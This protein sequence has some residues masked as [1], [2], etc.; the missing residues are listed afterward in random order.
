MLPLWAVATLL[1]VVIWPQA[2]QASVIKDWA[3][4]TDVNWATGSNWV[5]GSKPGSSDAA[6]FA[7]HTTQY[8]PNVGNSGTTQ[9]GELM[10][11]GGDWNLTGSGSATLQINGSYSGSS[12]VGISATG[13]NNT[14][15]VPTVMFNADQSWDIETGASLT[16]SGYV[17]FNKMGFT[18]TGDGTLTLSHDNSADKFSTGTLSAGT[19]VV[20]NANALGDLT[21]PLN[22]NGGTL[23]LATDTS[24]SAYDMVVGGNATI[25]S[26]RATAGAGI[27]HTLGTL[28]IG[29]N[30]LTVQKGTDVTSGTAG[31]T[32]GA[33]TLTG[34]ATIN[35]NTGAL[36]TLGAVSG[37]GKNFAIG[38]AG[39]TT[40]SGV[41][42]TTTG[43]LTKNGAGT[44][45]LSGANTYTGATTI[46]AGTIL[47]QNASAFSAGTAV[48]V[49]NGAALAVDSG[50]TLTKT[51]TWQSGSILGGN[52]KYDIGSVFGSSGVHIAPGTSIGTL[53]IDDGVN[54]SSGGILDVQVSGA[55]ADLLNITNTSGTGDLTL[56]GTSVLNVTE[57]NPGTFTSIAIVTYAGTRSGQFTTVNLPSA[58][59]SISYDDLGKR[60][61]LMPEPQTMTLMGVGSLFIGVPWIR[62]RKRRTD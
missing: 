49:Q 45:T 3:G 19:L 30:T 11:T 24:V 29:A 7:T 59:Y 31:L 60:I 13:G 58:A 53:T 6:R 55:T 18:K 56:G 57:L 61:L 20:A 17:N 16:V 36:T 39:N 15:S 23:D 52:G 22:L 50:V 27:T 47:V 32:F 8:Q 62:K 48:T 1:V 9:V 33:V 43:T 54:L 25:Q 10:F 38:G 41:I 46:S 2:A 14:I 37:S 5:G 34:N 12:G 35:T 40:I 51:A 4:G 28:S 26:D 21:K 44:L 42:G